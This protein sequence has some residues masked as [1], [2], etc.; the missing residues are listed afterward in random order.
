LCCRKN[1][2]QLI[3]SGRV[4]HVYHLVADF[5]L[6]EDFFCPLVVIGIPT[7]ETLLIARPNWT[8][9]NE[10]VVKTFVGLYTWDPVLHLLIVKNEA[11][12]G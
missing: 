9:L 8:V 11:G 3:P 2:S 6:I 12:V 1:A 4:I 7:D 5:C 10:A